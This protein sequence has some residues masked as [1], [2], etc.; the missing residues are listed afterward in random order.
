MDKEIE[1]WRDIQNYEGQYQISSFGRVKS[2]ARIVDYGHQKVNRK[3][4]IMSIRL[5]RGGYQYLNLGKDGKKKTFKVHRL[6]AEAFLPPINSK[7][8][9]DH[10]D[11]NK[12]NN[13]LNNLRWCDHQENIE[14][15]WGLGL[16][17]NVIGSKNH[18]SVLSEE[19]VL[20]I[21]KLIKEGTKN[22]HLVKMFNVK[23]SV[24]E[25]IKY[26]LTWKHIKI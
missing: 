8:H 1:I 24:I 7:N 14:F 26:G 12:E 21:K 10:I 20:T 22:R 2:L 11:G 6:V 16:Y 25:K 13:F 5:D 23:L 15:A 19:Q 4:V 9:V 17:N 3:E 18:Q